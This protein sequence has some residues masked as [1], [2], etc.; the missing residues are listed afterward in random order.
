M[1]LNKI[2]LLTLAGGGALAT[3][4]LLP[5]VGDVV[6]RAARGADAGGPV[7]TDAAG[8]RLASTTAGALAGSGAPGGAGAMQMQSQAANPILFVTQVPHRLDW[9]VVTSAT[10][11]HR[12]DTG[13]V[14]RGGDLMIRYADGSLRN[15]TQEAGYGVVGLQTGDNA[16]AVRGPCVHWSG[17][18]AVFSMV[19]GIGED[20]RWQLYEVSGLGQQ[21]TAQ[22][23]KL[24][25]QPAAYNNVDPAYTSDGRILFASDRPRNGA[26][27]LHPQLDEYNSLPTV[28]GFYAL[29]PVTA[30]L[31]LFLHTTSGVFRPTVDSFGRVV[32]S[33]WS[34]FTRDKTVDDEYSFGIDYGAFDYTSEEADAVST[35]QAVDMIPEAR[36]QWVDFVNWNP[37]YTGP[38]LGYEA[39]LIGQY[40]HRLLPVTINQDGTNEQTLNRLDRQELG[41][42]GNG[43]TWNSYELGPSF[44]D[45]PNLGWIQFPF[46]PQIAN[47]TPV[48]NLMQIREV[49]FLPGFYLAVDAR[50]HS[51]HAA[52]QILV[53]VAPPSLRANQVVIL[54]L[55]HPTTANPWP[56]APA[57]HSGL[58][59]D[60]VAL[61]NGELLVVHTPHHNMEND[62]PGSGEQNAFGSYRFR[63]KSIGWAGPHI[64]AGQP[65]TNGINKTVTVQNGFQQLTYSGP[66]HELSPVEVVARTPPPLTK[67]PSLPAPEVQA[68]AAAG[69]T[70]EL[71]QAGLELLGAAVIVS[72]N[73]TTRED[74]DTQQP[75]NLRVAGGGAQTLGA[76]GKVYDISHLQVFQGDLIRGLSGNQIEFASFGGRRV[77]GRPEHTVDWLNPPGGGP[78]GSVA[79]APDGSIAALVPADRAVT[80]QLVDPSGEAVVRERHWFTMQPGEVRVCTSCHDPTVVDQAGQAPPQNVPLALTQL[81][82]HLKTVTGL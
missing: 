18:K 54:P 9:N 19:R 65:L 67:A 61:T 36:R 37:A 62:L 80:W 74:Y 10:G 14:F 43:S 60:P 51:T 31:D 3:S 17:T 70:P 68:L 24:P 33:R 59:R 21:D 41:L 11:N 7:S 22:I 39:N 38:L 77:L 48:R 34:H 25:G 66:L 69:L 32:M 12:P 46:P 15:L 53:I 27:H 8:D 4:A 72:R 81:A 26:A 35:G 73:V 40:Q 29:D 6:A 75:Y 71:F 20:A 58:Y 47:P 23:T 78:P 57:G 79:I 45:D 64:V 76:G 42:I 2:L 55:T 44:N 82:S 30:K 52:G 5:Q 49:P 16:I 28:S 50:H 63:I 13:N 1:P 56:E